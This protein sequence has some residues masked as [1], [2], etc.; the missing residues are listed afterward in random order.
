MEH[1]FVVW[2]EQRGRMNQVLVPVHLEKPH[3]RDVELAR[4]QAMAE[5]KRFLHL[6]FAN[7]KYATRVA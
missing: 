4:Q 2:F 3:H 7:I 6:P 1:R 5:A